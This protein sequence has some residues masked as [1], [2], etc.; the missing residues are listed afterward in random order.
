VKTFP[1]LIATVA[2]VVLPQPLALDVPFPPAPPGAR[3]IETK[4]VSEPL[5][6]KQGSSDAEAIIAGQSYAQ[7][8]LEAPATTTAAFLACSSRPIAGNDTDLGRAL[9]RRIEIARTVCG[10]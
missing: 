4:Q 2:A 5:E 1:V 7:R 8:T 3:L 9:H 6:L 10:R